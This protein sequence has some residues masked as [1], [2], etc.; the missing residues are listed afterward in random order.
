MSQTEGPHLYDDGPEA[1]HTGTPRAARGLI[2]AVLGGTVL[3]AVGMAVGLPLVKGTPDEQARQVTGVFLD[4]LAGGDAETAHQ[5]LCEDER[6][7]VPA[8]EV[9]AEYAPAGDGEI[10]G[11]SA[12]DVDGV[13]VQQV[14]ISWP[15]GSSS[16][17]TVLSE[18][19]PRVCGVS[20]G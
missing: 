9:A 13:P 11:T 12:A 6:A 10:T 1:L 17:F 4:A 8:A 5:L 16:T 2:L 20:A 7:R 3:V 15:D 14:E 19:G 18:D